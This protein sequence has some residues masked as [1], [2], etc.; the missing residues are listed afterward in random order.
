M[1]AWYFLAISWNTGQP[2]TA[3]MLTSPIGS[4]RSTIWLNC[5]PPRWCLAAALR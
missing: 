5:R 1:L 2:V 3:A 4:R